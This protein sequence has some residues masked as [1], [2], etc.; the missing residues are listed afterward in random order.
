MNES[1]P[2]GPTLAEIES[3]LAELQVNIHRLMCEFIYW[4]DLM[5]YS[6]HPS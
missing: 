3:R 5:R 2:K 6:D 1:Q 4:N